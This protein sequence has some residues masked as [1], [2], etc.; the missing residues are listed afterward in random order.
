[1]SEEAFIIGNGEI[2]RIT[3]KLGQTPEC[4]DA[5][6]KKGDVVR[7]RNKKSLAT[8]P[9]EAVVGV[10]IPPN[11]SPTHALADLL[12]EP[13]PLMAQVGARTVT[14][15]LVCEGD[16]T[17]YLINERDLLPSGKEPVEIGSV[18]RNA[19]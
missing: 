15:I 7:V 17:P 4:P 6:F 10:A 9:R 13:R 3:G 14:Y 1:M 5:L 8:F 12:G 11:F 19:S 18:L 16:T 2:R